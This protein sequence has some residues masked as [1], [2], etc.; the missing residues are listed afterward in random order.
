MS[1]PVI[2]LYEYQI[3][4]YEPLD[5]ISI[6]TATDKVFKF[7]DIDDSP[8]TSC[9]RISIDGNQKSVDDDTSRSSCDPI[10]SVGGNLDIK[11]NYDIDNLYGNYK[12][13]LAKDTETM[14]LDEESKIKVL[15][16]LQAAF[17]IQFN[18][19][20][21]NKND[22][23][24]KLFKLFN[25]QYDEQDTVLPKD[26]FFLSNE[27][28]QNFA[29][30]TAIIQTLNVTDETKIILFGDFHGSY[31]TFFRSLCRLHRYGVLNL[32]TFKINDNYKIIFLGDILD[33]GMYALDILNIIFKLMI[34][35]NTP[36]NQKII[37]NRGN[38]E[39]Y[40]QYLLKFEKLSE[41]IPIA[42]LEFSEKI[43][44][45]NI[46]NKYIFLFNKLLCILPSA[47]LIKHT[48][49]FK[50][51][52]SHG[53][54]S[55]DVDL[56][57]DKIFRLIDNPIIAQDIRWSDFNFYDPTNFEYLI[58][59]PSSRNPTDKNLKTFTHAG[60]HSFLRKNNI[61][62]IIRGHQDSYAN[63]SLFLKTEPDRFLNLSHP[64][65]VDIPNVVVHNKTQQFYGNRVYGPIA[66]L[67]TNRNHYTEHYPVLTIST[68]TDNGRYL[69]ADSFAVLRFDI[70]SIDDFSR[71]TLS[72]INSIKSVLRNK[73]I[74]KDILMVKHLKTI[75]EI[76]KLMNV[77]L[78]KIASGR[79]HT[80]SK[81]D[82]K[83]SELKNYEA[84]TQITEYF[85][86]IDKIY[87]YYLN[88]YESLDKK[89]KTLKF[90]DTQ[91]KLLDKFISG[92]KDICDEIKKNIEAISKEQNEYATDL[93][94]D[95]EN[96]IKAIE[97][98]KDN[99][100]IKILE[101][102]NEKIKEFQI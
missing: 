80:I 5:R 55:F 23:F 48:H 38:H 58:F 1:I 19:I 18:I 65:S 102:I 81:K 95:Y 91:K 70:S 83:E 10:F 24:K 71:N 54:F 40:D 17:D 43:N 14:E 82:L 69:N 33:R 94:Y 66:R 2:E 101:Q 42:G 13:F 21:N 53:G 46:F 72:I 44:N 76:V 63:S 3:N 29:N 85:N 31:H 37:F 90:T 77:D 100:Q 87:K 36:D 78:Y 88:K 32:E 12:L 28:L 56:S 30:D 27:K 52:C 67:M 22:E 89:I 15:T 75:L 99:K 41:K 26:R 45:T 61:D 20:E 68:N 7:S 98:L 79:I 35:N 97:T 4:G 9:K 92:I 47:I 59:G 39:N 8:E 11:S 84:T 51:W 74:N 34:E 50:F 93:L 73:N 62:F 6:P 25:K 49:K 64:Q 86:D 96:N 16:N 57:E 60:T